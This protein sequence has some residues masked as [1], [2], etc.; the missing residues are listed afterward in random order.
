MCWV[1]FKIILNLDLLVMMMVMMM[2]FILMFMLEGTEV[3]GFLLCQFVHVDF[4]TMLRFQEERRIS[5][6]PTFGG[7]FLSFVKVVLSTLV[8]LSFD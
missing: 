4:E 2:V 6:V 8:I 3:G 7:H 1:E 5:L